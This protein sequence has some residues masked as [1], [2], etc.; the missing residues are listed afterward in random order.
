MR[1]L[2]LVSVAFT[3][4]LAANTF[5]AGKGSN[6]NGKPFIEIAG[7][8]VEVEGEVSSLQDQVDSLVGRVDSLEARVTADETAITSLQD[9]N[10]VLQATIDAYADTTD[11]LQLQINDIESTNVLLQGQIDA[12]DTLLQTQVDENQ[13]LIT[14]LQMA[15]NEVGDLQAQIDN[16][17]SLISILESEVDQINEGLALKQTIIS[18]NCPNDFAVQAINTD[19][20]VVCTANTDA[21]GVIPGL[22]SVWVVMYYDVEKQATHTT[23]DFCPTGYIASGAGLWWTWNFDIHGFQAVSNYGFYR[24]RNKTNYPSTYVTITTCLK[25]E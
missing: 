22:K 19:G 11:A 16:N 8:I 7:Q 4:V 14:S 21:G 12:G 17:A 15:I 6:P 2:K 5:A 18:G 3:L 1:I 24:V 13:A 9:Q 23:Q 20:S 10:V 25:V